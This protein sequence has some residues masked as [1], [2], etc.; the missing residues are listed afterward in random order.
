MGKINTFKQMLLYLESR[1]N[2]FVSGNSVMNF[3]NSLMEEGDFND[4]V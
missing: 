3:L 1:S 2:N 4:E